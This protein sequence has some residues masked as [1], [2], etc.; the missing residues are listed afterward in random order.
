MVHV[1][2]ALTVLDWFWKKTIIAMATDFHV[3]LGRLILSF[4]KRTLTCA[5]DVEF[6]L[7]I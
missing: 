5:S 4:Y 3:L 6:T 1:H 7:L 2:D